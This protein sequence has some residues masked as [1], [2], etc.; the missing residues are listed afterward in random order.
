MQLKRK[1]MCI[2]E[3]KEEK[4]EK[5]GKNFLLNTKTLSIENRRR[6]WE[7]KV[8]IKPITRKVKFVK[9]EEPDEEVIFDG[10]IDGWKQ[11]EEIDFM[12]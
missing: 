12:I 3:E 10:C 6:L 9:K 2:N 11:I 5:K 7:K 1:E 4:K 8:W